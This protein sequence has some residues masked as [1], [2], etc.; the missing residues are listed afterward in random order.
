MSAKIFYRGYLY[1]ISTGTN[2]QG[3]ALIYSSEDQIVTITPTQQYRVETELHLAAQHQ[4]DQLHLEGD[5]PL[6]G[7]YVQ[8]NGHQGVIQKIMQVDGAEKAI[9]VIEPKSIFRAIIDGMPSVHAQD[10]VIS[11]LIEPGK[12]SKASNKVTGEFFGMNNNS[13]LNFRI[14][15][16]CWQTEGLPLVPRKEQE[17]RG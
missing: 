17:P 13:R 5:T 11:L 8:I 14:N 1:S 7:D 4:I 12:L 2:N 16:A 3:V 6:A 9:I 10:G 15:V